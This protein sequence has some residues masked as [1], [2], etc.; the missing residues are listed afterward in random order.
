MRRGR[1]LVVLAF[2]AAMAP[3]IA[4]PARAEEGPTLD[5]KQL[6]EGRSP[7]PAIWR[8]YREATLPPIDLTNGPDLAAAGSGPLQLSL[9]QFLRLVVEN[10]LT[11]VAAR[12]NMAIAE[13]DVLRAK[14]GQAARGVAGAPLPNAVFAGAIG[15]GVST[16]A[17]LSSGG[18]GGA[19]IS[20]QG[21]LV[22]VGPRGV[23]DPTINVNVSYDRLTNPLNTTVVAGQSALVIPTTVLQTRFQQEL[24]I[25][26][27]YSVSLNLQRQASTQTGLLFD[28][29]LSSFG[30][31]QVYQPL[32]NGF[33][34]PFTQRFVTL[35][36]NNTKIVREAFHSTL[37][38]RL[39]TAANAYW[40]TV[41]L[42]E[43]LRLAREAV[44][45]AERQRREDLERVD[46]G[47][48]S[49]IDELTSE[50]QVAQAQ[51]QLVSAQ[52][53]FQQQ[54]ALLETFVSREVGGRL[55]TT[56]IEVTEALP[57]AT[58]IETPSTPD[59]V[60]RALE[61]RSSIRQAALTVA[62]QKIAEEYTRKNLLP[63]F[64]AYFALDVYGLAPGTPP[65]LRDLIHLNYP[66]Y[67][68][69]F[70]WSM[71]VLNRAA[72][73]DDVRA[74]LE[75]QQSETMLQRTRRQVT[76]QVQNSTADIA[77]NRA[78]V[79]ASGRALAASRVAYEGEQERLSFGTSTPYRVLLAQ[80]D[81]TASEAADVQARVNYAKA[82]AAY[83]VAISSLLDDNGI[84]AGAAERGNLFVDSR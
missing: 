11:L 23:F 27:S 16:T 14:S 35:A 57:E 7:F 28:P 69:G 65:A 30:A 74:R 6:S 21:K 15:A 9:R 34:R 5:L 20:T 33:G 42:R 51:T 13:V 72:Q 64:S 67:S 39:S 46:I 63:I 24:A 22:T 66:E 1:L 2:A 70:T 71:P 45:L 8:P 80:R 10:D 55:M 77:Q 3:A 31:F 26:T 58:D 60:A 68:I 17:P 79:L 4:A 82:K 49:P 52:T 44:D 29:S 47:T 32:M 56:P 50:S 75:T 83:E 18:T 81:L 38:D 84:D 25:G 48:L 76:L 19:A 54:T 61:R 78:R 43:N 12:Y 41:A 40:D 36:E 73:A 37:N 62:N 53:A 59:S